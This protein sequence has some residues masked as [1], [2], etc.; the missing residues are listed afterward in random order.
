[1]GTLILVR[2]ASTEFNR[3]GKDE[4]LR[5]WMDVPLNQ[6]GLEEALD[7][8]TQVAQYDVERIYTSDLRRAIQTAGLVSALTGAPAVATK[9]L[10]PWNLGLLGGRKVADV[11]KHL[12]EL[13]AHPRMKAPGGES[14][15]DFYFRYSAGLRALARVAASSSKPIV[16]IT[17]VR[18]FL[19]T[20]IILAG[21][22]MRQVPVSG[23]P[24]PG[25]VLLIE[26]NGHAWKIKAEDG[27]GANNGNGH[28]NG[29]NG[30]GHN[31]RGRTA[32]FPT[33]TRANGGKGLPIEPGS[34]Q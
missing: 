26:K 27:S 19:A 7:A 4:R 15:H 33:L 32:V 25:S 13:K 10:R 6:E 28:G 8:A 3:P 20:P 17:H 12:D 22:N 29:H 30:R 24:G 16:V 14:F 18:N 31:G 9:S 1:M 23:G 21:G 34:A 11:L 2:H 5:A